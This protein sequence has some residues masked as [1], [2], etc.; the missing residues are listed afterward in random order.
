MPLSWNE[1]R[2][3]ATRFSKEWDG[4]TSERADAQTF[5]NE[6]FA[7]FGITRKRVAVFEK[8]VELTRA[9]SRIKRGRID[10]FWKGVLLVEHK[11][12]GEDLDKA[13]EQAADYFDGIAERDLPRYIIVS[14]FSRLR[15][16]DLI[17]GNE[18]E[19]P[20]SKLRDNAGLF[21]FIAGYQT[22]KIE[23]KEEAA[24]IQAAE[25]LGKLHDLLKAS[26]Y[27]GHP[28]EVLLVRVLFCLF[29]DDTGI[30][31]KNQF[32]EYL[33]TRTAEDGSDLGMHIGKLFE[34]L[35]TPQDRR[36]GRLDEQLAA[37]TYVNGRLFD[38][39]LLL[40]DFDSAMRDA[41]L[42]AS[43]LDWSN[44]SPAIFGSL[45]QSIMD[46]EARR[47]LGA[48]YTR[49]VNILKALRPLLLDDLKAELDAISNNQR[50]LIDFQKKLASIRILDPACG[51]GNFLVIAY[52]ELRLLELE[53]LRRLYQPGKSN[54]VFDVKAL[55]FVDV[56]QFCGI[57]IE[58]F[59]AQI[60][61]VALWLTDHQMN[62]RVSDEFGQ[63]FARLPLVKSPNIVRDNALRV[64]W[65]NVAPP[66]QFTYIVGNPPFVGKHY[67]TPDQRADLLAV[68]KDLKA[69]GDLD[70]VAAWYVRAAN[71]IR[72]TAIRCAFV[73]TNSIT[74]GEQVPV[75]W[76]TL[77][78]KGIHIHF[79]HRTFQW[80]SEARGKAAVHC[81]IVGFGL[82]QLSPCR[83]FEYDD[84]QGDPHE[85]KVPTINA[86]LAP[87]EEV[88]VEKQQK[89][90]LAELP[91][92]R[93]GNKPSDGGNL[94]LDAEERTEL[95]KRD[96]GAAPYVKRFLGS[97][98]FLYNLPRYCLWLANAPPN[99]LRTLPHVMHRVKEVQKF[100]E[101]S[102]AEPTRRA[103]SR[104]TAFFFIS[105]PTTRYILIPE[106]SSEKRKYVPVGF[107]D[108]DVI[109]SNKVYV[110]SEPS[111]YIFGVLQS[112]M[113]MAWLRTVGGR[114]ESRYQY[115]ATMVYNTFP[116]PKATRGYMDAISAA[117][118][119]VLRARAAFPGA[120]L[121]DLYDPLS[122]PAELLKAHK[123]LDKQ[124][125]TAYGVKSFPSEADRVAFLFK[126][127]K[128]ITSPLALDQPVQKPRL[129]RVRR[130]N[131]AKAV[132][133]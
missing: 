129:R 71:F 65:E 24:N 96:P 116:C 122:M 85:I 101:A 30:F 16:Y 91:V 68:C 81:V 40:A 5:W 97:D 62:L 35:N 31:D 98:E 27:D 94:L 86:Y 100:R 53:V 4:V 123:A 78:K 7:V 77:R 63:Y 111:L 66:S 131:A 61:Q 29:A 52:R 73:S 19:F 46:K 51:C 37:F 32:R 57:E 128:E 44:I 83:L 39:R 2:E 79:A 114:L 115:S 11:S 72:G 45:F 42:D 70:Y 93:C 18:R 109:A 108:P 87:A 10:A 56:D 107:M 6:F 88:I 126:R 82:E 130:A 15:L 28:L 121:A 80:S 64:A 120:S 41:L 43:V 33:E 74:Q 117:A 90:L 23:E 133:S 67:R 125:D 99:V 38:E 132:K 8:Q 104:P 49:E 84:V 102:T 26:G 1:I 58:E 20:L 110:V 55:V 13:F 14:D 59:P 92:M 21:G 76:P 34:V 69:A 25:Q 95:L 112:I 113:H 127:Y 22:H 105:Q 48:H 106:V 17:A 47:N 9:G 75:L 89:P 119:D 124:V 36:T 3:R 50:R 60:A 118:N 103:A 12:A 54:R